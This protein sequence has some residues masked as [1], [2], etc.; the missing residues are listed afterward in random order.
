[1]ANNHEQFLEFNE[2][3]T[4]DDS[5]KDELRTN[6]GALRKVIDDYFEEFHSDKVAPLYKE[7]GSYKMHTIINPIP[8]KGKNDSGEEITLLPY[9][10]DDGIYFEDSLDSR[11]S[12]NTYHNWIYDAV[13]NHTSKGA[14]KKNTC[15]RVLYA[16]GHHIDLPI[17]FQEKE[18]DETPWKI[19]IPELAHKKDDWV[20]SDPKEFYQWFNAKAKDNYQLRRLVRY[21]KAWSDKQ[22]NSYSTKMPSGIVLT[23]LTT[24]NFC[25]NERD[26]IAFLNTTKA[27]KS[28]LDY[29]YRCERPTTKVGENLI[30]KYSEEH[31]KDRLGKLIES[32]DKAVEKKSQKEGCKHWQRHFGDRFVC[33]NIDEDNSEKESNKYETPAIVNVNAGSA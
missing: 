16:N 20:Q 28:E 12:I 14:I 11:K 8:Q 10:L 26:D 3:I 24:K 31:F 7:Q 32:G 6:R 5:K 9:D 21:I 13:K 33:S 1:M 27:I 4:L 25:P 18:S 22:N 29:I 2:T 30:H 19:I 17:Y 15:V 23:I